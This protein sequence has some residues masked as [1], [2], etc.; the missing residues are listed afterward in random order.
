MVDADLILPLGFKQ[1]MI[2]EQVETSLLA[3][4][5][6]PLHRRIVMLI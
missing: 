3:R 1:P 5:G 2:I 6:H 4:M